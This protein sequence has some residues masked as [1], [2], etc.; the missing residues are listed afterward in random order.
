L[1]EQK[2]DQERYKNA[3]SVSHINSDIVIK[4]L[5]FSYD[6]KNPVFSGLNLTIPF[7]KMTALIG[8]SGSGKSTIADLLLGLYA[9]EKGSISINGKL[10][11]QINMHEWR[12]RIGFVSQDTFVFN[13][14]IAENI[15]TGKY[16]ATEKEIHDAAKSAGAHEFIMQLPQGYETIV[17]DR[18]LKLSGGQRQRVAIARALIRDPDF[19]VFDEATSALDSKT[20]KAV[21]KSIEELGKKKTVLVIAHRLSPT[22]NAFPISF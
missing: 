6:G 1:A 4:D 21:Q 3:K 15:A 7:S 12:Q 9:P 13:T 2:Q 17:G 18:G 22:F 5:S 14:T 20:E 8:P 19:L 10:L 16:G 11:N